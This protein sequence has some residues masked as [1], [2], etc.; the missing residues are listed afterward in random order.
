MIGRQL[1]DELGHQCGHLGE[2]ADDVVE[3]LLPLVV[4]HV[5]VPSEHLDIRAQAG[6]RRSQLVRGIRDQLPLGAVGLLERRQ[7]RVEACGQPAELVLAVCLD[8]LGEILGFGHLLG[9][10]RQPANRRQGGL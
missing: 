3:Q 9:R 2:L 4:R 7:H 10:L 5:P 8:P 1:L 6:Q